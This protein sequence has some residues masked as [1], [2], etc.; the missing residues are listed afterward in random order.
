[1]QFLT[2]LMGIALLLTLS[3]LAYAWWKEDHLGHKTDALMR[4]GLFIAGT[5]IR[6][7]AS[8][9]RQLAACLQYAGRLATMALLT[10]TLLVLANEIVLILGYGALL[11]GPNY[12]AWLTLFAKPVAWAAATTIVGATVALAN[13]RKYDIDSEAAMDRKIDR[14]LA[15]FK[16]REERRAATR[17]NL[18][19]LQRH[20]D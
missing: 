14:A 2:F 10:G 20:I 11:E 15:R 8:V 17:A 7:S 4:R 19:A 3:L 13:L 16:E 12:E 1:M 5:P 9:L 18:E 6:F